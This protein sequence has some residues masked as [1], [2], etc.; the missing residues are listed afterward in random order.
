MYANS[1]YPKHLT[2][3]QRKAFNRADYQ[4]Q[5]RRASATAK[6]ENDKREREYAALEK[7]ADEAL[8]RLVNGAEVQTKEDMEYLLNLYLNKGD[9]KGRLDFFS[10]VDNHTENLRRAAVAKVTREINLAAREIEERFYKFVQMK[11]KR[12]TKRLVESFRDTAFES[13]AQTIYDASPKRP[14]KKV[15]EAVVGKVEE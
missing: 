10:I 8:N 1:E 14:T 12:D 5:Q 13:M 7:A 9:E 3:S 6:A 11:D 2:P 15:E 4:L